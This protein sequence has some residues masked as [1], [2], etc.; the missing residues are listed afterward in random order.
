MSQPG[1]FRPVLVPRVHVARSASGICLHKNGLCGHRI[2]NKDACLHGELVGR[3]RS[4]QVPEIYSTELE[5]Q[6]TMKSHGR[7]KAEPESGEGGR[8]IVVSRRTAR[9][10]VSWKSNVELG[11]E[12]R[13]GNGELRIS[14]KKMDKPDRQNAEWRVLS[15]GETDHGE[16]R[17]YT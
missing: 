6:M 15:V 7:W 9:E 14:L 2:W 4:P 3:P 12:W 1:V 13:M 5:E 10:E 17:R 11:I 16:G 8:I